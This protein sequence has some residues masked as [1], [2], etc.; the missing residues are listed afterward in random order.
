MREEAA[1]TPKPRR[2]RQDLIRE[3]TG[4]HNRLWS[5][6]RAR[7]QARLGRIREGLTHVFSD[8]FV[9]LPPAPPHS[10]RS[11]LLI[12]CARLWRETKDTDTHS[13]WAPRVNLSLL[14][15]DLTTHQ[16]VAFSYYSAPQGT[17]KEMRAE[18]RAP[19]LLKMSLLR[20]SN[21]ESWNT[22]WSSSAA[23]AEKRKIGEFSIP[24]AE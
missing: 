10:R 8:I 15:R 3:A 4:S 12:L 16:R 24:F 19:N 7:S 17:R 11:F 22:Y 6:G 2:T 13:Q 1:G 23:Q 5:Q 20:P 9:L 18:P 21:W 14:G